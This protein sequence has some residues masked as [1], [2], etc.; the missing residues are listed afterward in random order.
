MPRATLH[1]QGDR[2][3]YFAN[4]APVVASGVACC[5]PLDSQFVLGF[6]AE[7]GRTL[8]RLPAD[9]TAAGID[10]RVLWLAGALG[11]EARLEAWRGDGIGCTGEAQQ[12]HPCHK[13]KENPADHAHPLRPS[14]PGGV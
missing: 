11:D 9:A 5:T 4:N 13:T 14:V 7:D 2:P 12:R 3:V 1:R 10:H 8:W 6:D